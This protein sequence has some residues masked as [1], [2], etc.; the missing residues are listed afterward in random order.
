MNKLSRRG[1]ISAREMALSAPGQK[2][3][4]LDFV[5]LSLKGMGR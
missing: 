3:I 4:K 2:K 1:N 5:V